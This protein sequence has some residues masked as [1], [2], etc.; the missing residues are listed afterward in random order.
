MA[1]HSSIL[2]WRIPWTEDPGGLQSTGSQRVGQDT[3]E[4][5]TL[6]LP[7]HSSPPT[8]GRNTLR[9]VCFSFPQGK[10]MLGD[11]S[12]HTHPFGVKMFTEYRPDPP[13]AFPAGG[14]VVLRW[15]D[16]ADCVLPHPGK[17]RVTVPARTQYLKNSPLP[18]CPTF[19]P[20]CMACVILVPWPGIEPMQWKHSVLT[21]DLH[22]SP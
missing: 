9:V 19:G 14:W 15:A 13:A 8:W 11:E 2:A 16:S 10:F 4:R 18:T 20:G 12:I 21:T 22:G 17:F 7:F 6:S 5:L 3:T 1:T